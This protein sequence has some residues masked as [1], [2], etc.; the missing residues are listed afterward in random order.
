MFTPEAID[1]CSR[2]VSS[3]SG[4]IRR[5]LGIARRGIEIACERN[6]DLYILKQALI[7]SVPI[8]VI[9]EASRE[10]SESYKMSV[11]MVIN[12]LVIVVA[13]TWVVVSKS[14]A[15][16]D[17][18]TSQC[19]RSR[20]CVSLRCKYSH[21]FLCAD[22]CENEHTGHAICQERPLVSGTTGSFGLSIVH[23]DFVDHSSI[24]QSK[25]WRI[26]SFRSTIR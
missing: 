11:N 17:C 5:A 15:N 19:D 8:Q 18:V 3:I 14:F 22:L 2:K 1:L 9:S 6:L 12:T 13:E 23:W 26:L 24:N 7:R 21:V 25:K 16:L 10:H 20:F 4:D